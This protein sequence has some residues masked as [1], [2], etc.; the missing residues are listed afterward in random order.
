MIK[1]AIQRKVPIAVVPFNSSN[2]YENVV[3]VAGIPHVLTTY[4]DGRMDIYITG[5][6]KCLL[7]DFEQESPYQ[8]YHY[9]AL[10]EDLLMDETLE[11]DIEM[12]QDLLENW[13]NHFLTDQDQRQNF[14][15]TLHDPEILVNY[16]AVFLLDDLGSKRR[17][18]ELDSIGEKI[19]ALL[20]AVGPK[21][22]ALGPFLPTL[23]F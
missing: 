4:P 20:R 13:A 15:K 14:A 17:V 23:R 19:D 9:D 8:V 12:L 6:E 7:T 22:I 1:D 3:C 16:C 2:N 18:M 10:E 11:L 5:S 21:E